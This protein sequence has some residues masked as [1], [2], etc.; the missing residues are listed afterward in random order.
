MRDCSAVLTEQHSGS[1]CAAA[2]EWHQCQMRLG[3]ERAGAGH[4][5]YQTWKQLICSAFVLVGHQGESMMIST[6]PL[7]FCQD[8][9]ME[10]Y[11]CSAG[12]K[13]AP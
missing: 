5:I 7:H 3:W 9:L 11:T 1:S 10:K 4:L 6:L 8:F 12:G 2:G 13:E